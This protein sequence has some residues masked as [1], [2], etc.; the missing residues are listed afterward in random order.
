M[1]V[2]GRLGGSIVE[3]V[4]KDKE[5]REKEKN[6]VRNNEGSQAIC[7]FIRNLFEK[8]N[9]GY[10]WVKKNRTGLFPVTHQDS[11]ALCYF[12]YGDGKSWEGMKTKEI[13]A[14]EFSFQEMYEWYGLDSD[15][16]YSMLG[17]RTM[18]DTLDQ[19]IR[20]EVEKLPHIKNSNGFMV[21][22]FH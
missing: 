10:E 19:M 5:T 3:K 2:F 13:A 6:F 7:A 12:E 17:T 11:V 1:G 22:M 4:T 18:L 14:A 15:R 20:V 9:M 21:K 8:G 16:A